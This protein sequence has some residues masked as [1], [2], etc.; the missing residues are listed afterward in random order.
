MKWKF[1]G[2]GMDLVLRFSVREQLST[3]ARRSHKPDNS[4]ARFQHTSTFHITL[5]KAPTVTRSVKTEAHKRRRHKLEIDVF[6]TSIHFQGRGRLAVSVWKCQN[7]NHEAKM[8]FVCE[9]NRNDRSGGWWVKG[10]QRKDEIQ[11]Y[12]EA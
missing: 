8:S 12:S 10:C 7:L 11:E 9:I 4:C 2:P 1:N 6:P 5:N 3:K